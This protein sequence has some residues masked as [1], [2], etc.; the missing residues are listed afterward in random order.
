MKLTRFVQL[1]LE[2][3][4]SFPKMRTTL[5]K[6]VFRPEFALP[7]IEA[8]H[9][10]HILFSDERVIILTNI[11]NE[12]KAFHP[13]NTAFALFIREHNQNFFLYYC[14]RRVKTSK[15]LVLRCRVS[16]K[17]RQHGIPKNTIVL[18]SRVQ[19]FQKPIPNLRIRHDYRMFIRS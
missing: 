16:W 4:F 6:H 9:S 17:L 2:M 8:F 18:N 12:N 13:T 14:Q 11:K 1:L 7:F 15:V 5:W 19:A 10:W 3:F